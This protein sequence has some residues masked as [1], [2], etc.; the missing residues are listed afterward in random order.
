LESKGRIVSFK[1]NTLNNRT[2]IEI[3]IDTADD[4]SLQDL[5]R[6]MKSDIKAHIVTY[7][8]PRSNSA[9]KYFHTLSDKLA[10]EMRMSKPKMKNYLLYHYGQKVRD[11]DGK[12]VLIKTNADEEQLI[13]RTDIHLY[14]YKDSTDGVPMYVLLEHS[15]FYDSK[16]MSIL[17]DG[18]VAE[19]K[20]VGIETLPPAEIERLKALWG[21]DEIH[22]AK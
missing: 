11:E 15:R 16:A 6:L 5:E 21:T 2:L 8:E 19:C 7:R 13:S 17:I 1:P 20:A 10:D 22:I 3:E 9:N 18:V 12:L 4:D 14:Y